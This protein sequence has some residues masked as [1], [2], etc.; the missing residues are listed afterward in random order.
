MKVTQF[1]KSD[2]Q[3]LRTDL[4]AYLKPFLEERGL[5]LQLGNARFDAG[6]VRFIG[7]TFKVVGGVSEEI[8]LARIR[9]ALILERIIDS[10]DTRQTFE[11]TEYKLIGYRPKATKNPWLAKSKVDGKTYVLTNVSARVH[12]SAK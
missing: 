12:F 10:S 6:S 3:R 1:T 8:D 7:P 9:R 5:S 4:E 11:S 2:V